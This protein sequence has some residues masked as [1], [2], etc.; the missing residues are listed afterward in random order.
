M[1]IIRYHY[2]FLLLSSVIFACGE[3]KRKPY[4]ANVL[5]KQ[6]CSN[7]HGVDGNLANHGAVKLQFSSL[8]LE[9]RILV[10]SQGRNAMTGFSRILSQEEIDSIANYTLTFKTR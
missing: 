4:P 6:Y 3:K 5:F 8:S 7:C 2:I 1:W 9:E 10:I